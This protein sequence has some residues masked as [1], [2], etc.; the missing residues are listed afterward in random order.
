MRLGPI[1]VVYKMMI[2]MFLKIL[3]ILVCIL[4]A[5]EAFALFVGMHLLSPSHNPWLS[6]KNDSLLGLDLVT[7]LGLIYL[8]AV[9][10]GLAGSLFWLFVGIGLLTHSYRA[11][12]YF[13]ATHNRF[14][15]NQALFIVNNLKLVGLGTV[16]VLQLIL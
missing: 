9:Q 6:A 15:A 4:I 8:V 11:W 7:G 5:G 14:C 10:D 12:E 3:A 13:A 16:G 1:K 2:P